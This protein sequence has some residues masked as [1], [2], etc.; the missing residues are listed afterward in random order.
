[1][2]N[3]KSAKKRAIQSETKRMR[4][5]A[6]KTKMKNAIKS[7]RAA[8]TENAENAVDVLNK[9]KSVIAVSA[10]KGVINKKNMARKISRLAKLVNSMKA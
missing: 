7:V 4:N 9:A 2:A 10:K 8:K 5:M 6:I 1:M 3:H